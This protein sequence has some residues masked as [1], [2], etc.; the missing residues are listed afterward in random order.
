MQS[1]QSLQQLQPKHYFLT[2]MQSTYRWT[3]V[4]TI[5]QRSSG[6]VESNVITAEANNTS[7]ASV[8]SHGMSQDCCGA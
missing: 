4:D 2:K 1:L 8:G 3:N 5:T 6:F 7:P